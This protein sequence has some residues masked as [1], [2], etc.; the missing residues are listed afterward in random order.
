[1][2]TPDAADPRARATE[3]SPADREAYDRATT[4]AG[5]VDR[6]DAGKLVLTGA[7]R[8]AFLDGQVSNDVGGLAAGTGCY[9]TFLTPKGKIRGDL[10]ILAGADP[11]GTAA[12]AHLLVCE[13]AALQDLFDLV[14]R[15]SIGHE[16][17]LHK[18]TV[19]AGLLSVVGPHALRAGRP[20]GA[21]A[22]A[23]LADAPELT[24]ARDVLGPGGP[25]AL[26]V[27]TDR[28]VDLLFAADDADAVR[29][30]LADAGV[31]EIPAH[32]D[33]VVRV[34]S[35]RPRLGAELDE[36]VM[37]AEAGLEE[38]AVSFTKGCYVGQETVARLHWRGRPNRH[39]RGLRLPGPAAVGEP[40]VRDGREVGAVRTA[41]ISPRLGPIG[42]AYL[43]REVEPGDVVEVAGG[44]AVAVALPF[45]G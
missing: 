13:R 16:V 32:V 41:A 3:L 36:S 24:H 35:G 23:A 2:A 29:T 17:E 39:L 18:R 37:P 7:D 8:A 28:G 19:Q 26:A 22:A 10:R 27:R 45:D 6:S 38:R 5:F 34:E 25:T 43:R 21:E 33:E 4:G 15:F 30:A 20:L 42:L 31:H 9:A 1:M 12:D 44:R 14:R 11:L 40:V